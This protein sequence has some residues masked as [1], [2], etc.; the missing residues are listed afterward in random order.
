MLKLVRVVVSDMQIAMLCYSATTSY[1]VRRVH[2]CALE[3]PSLLTAQ[4]CMVKKEA[5]PMNWA[6]IMR[7]SGTMYD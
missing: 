5:H 2:E 3:S 7:A 6:F 1:S 4:Y